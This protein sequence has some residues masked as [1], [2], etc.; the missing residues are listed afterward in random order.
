MED[1]KKSRPGWLVTLL[2]VIALSV[3]VRVYVIEPYTVSGRSMQPALA[4]GDR[5]LVAKLAYHAQLP[6]RGDIIVFRSPHDAASDYVKRVIGLPGDQVE[7]RLG[8]V[9]ING[10]PLAEPYL[11][12][13]PPA[14]FG[15]ASVP[16]DGVFVLGD[17]R[18]HSEDSRYFGD[19]PLASIKG[20]VVACFWPL[21]R[22]GKPH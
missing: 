18:G 6:R 7:L 19:V 13:Y 3:A 20:R 12:Q 21:Q 4:D 11:G 1:S 16:A 15:P 22:V 5:L 17:N 2:L 10:A 14:D 9:Y 8:R